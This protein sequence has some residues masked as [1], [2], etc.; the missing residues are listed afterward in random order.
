MKK[1]IFL[2]AGVFLSVYGFAQTT[3]GIKAGPDFSSLSMKSDGSK[4]TSK[5]L[6]GVEGG[7]YANLPVA[8]QLVVQPA[9]L[10]TGKGGKYNLG[11]GYVQTQRLNYITLPIDLLYEAAMPNGSGTW[12]FGAGPYLAY[13][14]SGKVTDNSPTP[15]NIN[16]FK[17]YGE[18]AALKRFDAGADVQIGYEMPSGFNMGLSADLGLMNLAASGNQQGTAHNTSFAI[19]LGYTFRKQ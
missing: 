19:L 1:I 15:S 18:G 4:T 14:L 9:L 17:D 16:P 5:G 10:Y 11:E 7:V 3:F 8:P 2:A 12:F 6:I 13:G